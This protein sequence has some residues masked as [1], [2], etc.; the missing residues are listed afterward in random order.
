MWLCLWSCVRRGGSIP[1]P[2]LAVPTHQ[3]TKSRQEA[4]FLGQQERLSLLKEKK[5]ALGRGAR[6]TSVDRD[7]PVPPPSFPGCHAG[8]SC[9]ISPRGPAALPC[10]LAGS[11]TFCFE[12]SAP[13]LTP[14]ASY[15][16]IDAGNQR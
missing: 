12:N 14:L 3:I 7:P 4:S 13:T 6:H 15:P 10:S 11:F 5:P 8:G 16:V 1:L 9:G 2:S